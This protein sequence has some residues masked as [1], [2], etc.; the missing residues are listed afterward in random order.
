MELSIKNLLDNFADDKLVAPKVLEK[1]MGCEDDPANLHQLQIALD[2]LERVGILVKERGKYRRLKD[3]NLVEGKLRCS[4]KG[5]CFA[6][7]DD[8]SSEDIYIRESQLSNAWNGD[9][10]LVQVTKEGRRRRSPEGEVRLILERGNPSVLARVRRLEQSWR[11]K[12]LDDRLLFELELLPS[13]AVVDLKLAEDQLVHV[14]IVRYPLGQYPPLGKIT[15]ILGNDAQSAADTELVC[16]KYGLNRNFSEAVRTVAASL[17]SK[18]KKTDLKNRLD[19]RSLLTLAITDEPPGSAFVDAAFSLVQTP[20]GDWQLGVHIADVS[21]YVTP[22]SPLDREA[23]RRGTTICLRGVTLPLLPESPL[24]FVPEQERLAVSLLVTLNGAGELLEYELQPSV[25]QVDQILNSAQVQAILT[26]SEAS[27]EPTPAVTEEVTQLARLSQALHQQRLQRGGFE[28][29]L[30]QA[31]LHTYD[32]EGLLP[33]LTVTPA[34][35]AHSLVAEFLL[36]ANQTVISHLQTL[37]VP[38][39]Y[40]VQSPP[41]LYDVQELLKLTGNLGIP[42]SLSQEDTVQ[43]QDYQNF[44]R[45]L[46][47]SDVAPLLMELLLETL[48]PASDSAVSG[49]HFSLASVQGY[50]HFT[51][52]LRRYTD[53]LNHR[54]LHAI[55]A[56]GRD[57]RSSRSKEQV[58]LRHSSAVGQISWNVLPP[59]IQRELEAAIT[60]H[61]PHL[62]EREKVALQVMKDLD[63]LMK[64]KQM[65]E[66]TGEVFRGLITGIQSYGFFVELEELMVEGLVHVSSLRDD[67]YE[68]RSRQQ[69]L[70]GRKNRRQYRLGDRVEV[71]VKNVDYYR[72]QIDLV[73]VGGGSEATEEDLEEPGVGPE[74]PSTMEAELE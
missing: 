51:A 42:L 58:N 68:Y 22:D 12:P 25:I 6:I 61:L 35:I 71:Q 53:I 29:S 18:L 56:E 74:T 59:E 48:K 19:L 38:A 21:H 39:V 45:Q 69:T 13:E 37:G 62:Q 27:P 14:E 24:G 2:A 67:W 30:A 66:R 10:V 3:E 1:K 31:Y 49:P 11:G 50:G 55:F 9:R 70:I 65:Q 34:A 54:V 23:S 4:S 17:P 52:P 20:T 44:I 72:Q 43:P 5:F 26:P 47:T 28:I 7:Q 63:G 8:D 46:A 32:D 36:L 64:V 57:R 40:R 41:E 15:Q 16:C 73:V 33:A 60:L